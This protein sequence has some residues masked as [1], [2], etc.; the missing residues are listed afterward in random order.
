M[1]N[2]TSIFQLHDAKQ[3]AE[4]TAIDLLT[5]EAFIDDMRS[6]GPSSPPT[7]DG[8][9]S[10]NAYL[11]Q[12]DDCPDEE[13]IMAERLELHILAEEARFHARLRDLEGKQ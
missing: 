3:I 2:S 7:L 10:Y 11:H 8:L 9:L 12:Y 4:M 1:N 13:A 6:L 5:V